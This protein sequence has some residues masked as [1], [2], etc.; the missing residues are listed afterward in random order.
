MTGAD[1]MGTAEPKLRDLKDSLKPRAVDLSH[2]VPAA[3]AWP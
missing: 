1:V 3:N 2:D